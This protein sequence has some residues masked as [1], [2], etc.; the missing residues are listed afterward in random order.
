[1]ATTRCSVVNKAT[2]KNAANQ[3]PCEKK[4]RSAW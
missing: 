4:P 1:M 3:K 2:G